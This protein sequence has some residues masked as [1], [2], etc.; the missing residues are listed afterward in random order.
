[1]VG[2]DRIISGNV[3]ERRRS[4]E[5]YILKKKGIVGEKDGG[6]VEIRMKEDDMK[7][8]EMGRKES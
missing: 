5:L 2:E 1:M 4:E 6:E 3:H 8:G 7:A